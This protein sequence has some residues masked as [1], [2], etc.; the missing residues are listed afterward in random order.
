MKCPIENNGMFLGVLFC[1]LADKKSQ[2][3]IF[4]I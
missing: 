3:G 2:F 1:D 4:S